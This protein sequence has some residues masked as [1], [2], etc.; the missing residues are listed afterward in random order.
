MRKEVEVKIEALQKELEAI[1]ERMPKA[2]KSG[3]GELSE[4]NEEVAQARRRGGARRPQGGV[5]AICRRCSNFCRPPA[6][7]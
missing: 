7:T 6:A 5:S 3:R 1:L 2:D 4:L